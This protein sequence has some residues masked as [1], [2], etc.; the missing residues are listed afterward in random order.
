MN[1]TYFNQFKWLCILQLIHDN[2]FLENS[3]P[4][5]LRKMEESLLCHSVVTHTLEE[6]PNLL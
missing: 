2:S 5:G 4:A 3:C 6:T 1:A